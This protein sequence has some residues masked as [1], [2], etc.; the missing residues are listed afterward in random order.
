MHIILHRANTFESINNPW[1]Q[2]IY[3]IE[4]DVWVTSDNQI[5]LSHDNEAYDIKRRKIRISEFP[6]DQLFDN[7]GKKLALLS[8][9]LDKIRKNQERKILIEVKCGIEIINP[10][11]KM[12]QDKNLHPEQ[13]K[14][15]GFID[16]D[17]SKNTMKKIAE[18]FKKY[19]IYAVFGRFV[20]GKGDLI[21]L[22]I[23]SDKKKVNYILNETEKIKAKGIVVRFELVSDLLFKE[24]SKRGLTKY[25]WEINNARLLPDM[26]SQRVDGVI[27][28]EP[29]LF[30]S[31]LDNLS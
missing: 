10:L 27:T 25:V 9:A 28:D 3:F 2:G 1:K 6:Y 24:A 16:N 20:K 8:N 29:I 15:I 17:K 21:K 11:K 7:Y 18:K 12:F 13:V 14:I 5:I 26:I 23:M 4:V 30:K 31:E 22:M 19:D